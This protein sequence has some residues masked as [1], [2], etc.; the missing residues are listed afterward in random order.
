MT[1]PLETID[2]RGIAAFLH[3]KKVAEAQ[4]SLF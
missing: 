4:D 3:K 2:D 1:S